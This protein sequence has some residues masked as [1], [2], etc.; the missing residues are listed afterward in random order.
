[1]L[2]RSPCWLINKYN[3]WIE[4]CIECCADNCVGHIFKNDR[5]IDCLLDRF[6]T[7]VPLYRRLKRAGLIVL[8]SMF[9]AIFV[10]I[11][12]VILGVICFFYIISGGVSYTR[13]YIFTSCMSYT[14]CDEKG[15]PNIAPNID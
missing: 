15:F 11:F 4:I 8:V 12:G 7:L 10:A 9:Y 13:F 6:E 2:F 3:K 5:C 1:M 14:F